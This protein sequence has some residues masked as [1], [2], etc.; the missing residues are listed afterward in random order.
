[1]KKSQEQEWGA[2]VEMHAFNDDTRSAVS[3]SV[4]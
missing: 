4:N 2:R 1:M 3:N